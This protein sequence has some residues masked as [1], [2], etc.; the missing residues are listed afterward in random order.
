MVCIVLFI[1]YMWARVTNGLCV[2]V[3][4]PLDQ[5]DIHIVYILWNTSNKYIQWPLLYNGVWNLIGAGSVFFP[6][7]IKSA[8]HVAVKVSFGSL[9]LQVKRLVFLKYWNIFYFALH[10]C[11]YIRNITLYYQ[12]SITHGSM[13]PLHESTS[14]NLYQ[15][16]LT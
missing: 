4:A 5:K 9:V 1:V 13:Q 12:Q 2:T 16:T 11:F 15:H 10:Y 14:Y 8:C 3:T 7:L 6:Y